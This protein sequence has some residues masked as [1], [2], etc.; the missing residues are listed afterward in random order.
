MK[1]PS[2]AIKMTGSEAV[3]QCLVNEGVNLVFGYPGG[4]IMPFYDALLAAE[5]KSQ[6]HHVLVRHEQGAAHA[7]EGYARVSRKVGVC[8]ATSGPGATNLVTGIADAM[9]DSIPIVCITGQ[10]GRSLLGTDAFQE[11]DIISIT[12]PITKWGYQITDPAEIPE[13]MAKAFH[14]ARSGRPG[15][16]LIDITK[17]AQVEKR[18]FTFSPYEERNP[19]RFRP[20]VK[21][22]AV[23]EAADIINKAERPIMFIGHGVSI[24]GAENEA[25]ALA[26]KTGMPVGV[27]LLGLS[28]FP[29]GHPLYGGMLGMHGNYSM[30]MLTNEADVILAIGMRFDDRVTGLAETY[31]PS[32]KIVHIDI[33][34]AE[35]G[36]NVKPSV[37]LVAD[38]KDALT[39]LYPLVEQRK[40]ELWFREFERLNGIE[41]EKVCAG[42]CRPEDGSIRM[43]EVLSLLSEK[44][45]GEAIVVADVGQNQMMSARYYRFRSPN[46][47]ITSGGL[48]TMGFALPASVGAK[49]AAPDRCVVAVVGDGGFQMTLQELGTI[50]QEGLAVKILMLNNGF[51]GMVRQWQQLFFDKRYS[52]VHLNNPDFSAICGAYGIKAEKVVDRDALNGAL[53]RF[54]ESDKACLLEVGVE[55]EDNVFPMV[56]AGAAVHE[57][58]LA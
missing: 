44:T 33:D 14:V 51:L 4:T 40:H 52:F 29:T 11:T 39:A 30:N 15:P 58:R 43:G 48:G 13:V 25:I 7:A 34:A 9:L 27:T 53:D 36:K 49:F 47:Y 41:D 8:I 57:V 21:T 55:R 54:L 46:S 2:E 31:A 20:P 37:S 10:V 3:V 17:N 45:K 42:A 28:S 16:V 22:K 35:V 1:L 5:Q 12:I 23:Q 56:P 38:A 32:A 50:M 6:L 24:S 19:E 26:E 18:K